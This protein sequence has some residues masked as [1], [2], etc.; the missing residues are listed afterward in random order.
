[1]STPHSVPILSAVITDD[2]LSDPCYRTYCRLLS[3]AWRNNYTQT[4]P[5]DLYGDVLPLLRLSQS[6]AREHLNI[7]RA[8]KLIRWTTN[9]S[10]VYTFT[11]PS[12]Q[13][14]T[15]PQQFGDIPSDVTIAVSEPAQQTAMANVSPDTGP[16]QNSQTPEL[17]YLAH[18]EEE[19][20]E[21]LFSDQANHHHHLQSSAAKTPENGSFE[22]VEIFEQARAA[23]EAGGV[24]S[25]Q[26]AKLAERWAV[27]SARLSIR[28]L[29]ENVAYVHD[30]KSDIDLPGAIMRIH[31]T[32]MR[33]SPRRYPALPQD[34]QAALNWAQHPETWS[35]TTDVPITPRPINER[36]DSWAEFEAQRHSRVGGSPVSIVPDVTVDESSSDP[37]DFVWRAAL[38]RSKHTLGEQLYNAIVNGDVAADGD[39]ICISPGVWPTSIALDHAVRTL[40]EALHEIT[41]DETLSVRFEKIE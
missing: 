12:R 25:D 37:L 13:Q 24:W 5:L 39:T 8:A 22:G 40:T 10:G 18:H 2:S 27:G 28:D 9:R 14:T 30:P 4:D 16:L 15:Q 36:P 31:V 23:I 17:G 20:E 41:E 11:F 35:S 32:S 3:R 6:K 34:F 21:D 38:A 7:L 29:L 33:K 1:M 26:A 19:D